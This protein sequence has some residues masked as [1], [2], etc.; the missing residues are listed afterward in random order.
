MTD[1]HIIPSVTSAPRC[2][3]CGF[4]VPT[5]GMV[6]ATC[7]DL[8]QFKGQ[9][10]APKAIFNLTPQK[11]PAYLRR[12]NFARPDPQQVDEDAL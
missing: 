9:P 3:G 6:C 8:P 10:T 12:G 4:T 7:A 11:E 1:S 2:L 5:Q